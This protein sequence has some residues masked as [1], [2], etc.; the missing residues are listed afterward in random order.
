MI[1]NFQKYR[2]KIYIIKLK[3]T[4]KKEKVEKENV[5]L[6]KNYKSTAVKMEAK[7]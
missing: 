6:M 4:M 5:N 3:C 7:Q 2:E 1:Y